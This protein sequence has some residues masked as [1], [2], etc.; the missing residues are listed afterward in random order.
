MDADRVSGW[1]F[2]GFEE[3]GFFVIT[4]IVKTSFCANALLLARRE[5]SITIKN[6]SPGTF[7][8]KDK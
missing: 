6:R 2:C 8:I 7:L 4:M 1:L 5:E 3:F